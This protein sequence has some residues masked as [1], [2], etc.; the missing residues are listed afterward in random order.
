MKTSEGSGCELEYKMNVAIRGLC[1]YA[2]H[3]CGRIYTERWK[4]LQLITLNIAEL[5]LYVNAQI[6]TITYSIID[7]YS[8]T[9]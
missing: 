8:E 6:Q 5:I 1:K 7:L 3:N 9:M 4:S 2:I